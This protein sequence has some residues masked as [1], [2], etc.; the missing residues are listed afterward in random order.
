MFACLPG[1]LL[2]SRSIYLSTY[3]P[4]YLFHYLA[5]CA[6][7]H[8]SVCLSL[9]LSLSLLSLSRVYT[10]LKSCFG[11]RA[12]PPPS[13]SAGQCGPTSFKV[14]TKG[15]RRSELKTRHRTKNPGTQRDHQRVQKPLRLTGVTPMMVMAMQNRKPRP[16]AGRG[17]LRICVRLRYPA[18]KLD[19]RRL[20]IAK[21]TG[22]H[23][24]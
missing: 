4:T 22:L 10:L 20:C 19:L 24:S 15:N 7:A 8:V 2:V 13:H 14:I 3:L 21:A 1:Y 11:F 16:T 12:K 5:S 17:F 6:S 23:H 9:S 18:R